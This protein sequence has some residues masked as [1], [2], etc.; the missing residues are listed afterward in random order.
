MTSVWWHVTHFWPS[1]HRSSVQTLLCLVPGLLLKNGRVCGEGKGTSEGV[2]MDGEEGG[3]LVRRDSEEGTVDGEEGR[4]DS[5][6]GRVDSK[7]GQ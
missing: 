6:E 1:S 2:R 3:W 4:V 7:G 5:E